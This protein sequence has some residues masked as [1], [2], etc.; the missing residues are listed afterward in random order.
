MKAV[1]S[2]NNLL[3]EVKDEL[4]L[5]N[6]SSLKERLNEVKTRLSDTSNGVYLVHRDSEVYCLEVSKNSLK[7]TLLEIVR[8]YTYS[9]KE[10]SIKYCYI[11][12][13]YK[14]EKIKEFLVENNVEGKV[15]TDT[16]LTTFIKLLRMK[17]L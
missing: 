12:S 14:L 16:E 13:E 9:L 6:K 4:K 17:E 8:M 5:E 3:E 10:F 11:R 15:I 7:E 2:L 1:E